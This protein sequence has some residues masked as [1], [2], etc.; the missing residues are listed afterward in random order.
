MWY[1]AVQHSCAEIYGHSNLISHPGKWLV[2]PVIFRVSNSGL[3]SAFRLNH[4]RIEMLSNPFDKQSYLDYSV[5]KAIAYATFNTSSAYVTLQGA[6]K[7]DGV[8]KD[9]INT[10]KPATYAVQS[11]PAHRISLHVMACALIAIHSVFNIASYSLHQYY[12]ADLLVL[13]RPDRFLPSNS[14]WRVAGP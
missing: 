12:T 6:T 7:L 2:V 14:W 11:L 5:N 4:L 9:F 10:N 1:Q 3:S 8:L 13:L